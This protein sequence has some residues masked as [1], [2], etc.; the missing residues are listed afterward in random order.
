M[1]DPAGR[2]MRFHLSNSE[3]PT[4]ALY[5]A[6]PPAVHSPRQNGGMRFRRWRAPAH[7]APPLPLLARVEESR[8]FVESGRAAIPATTARP[9]LWYPYDTL[10]GLVEAGE[11]LG[12]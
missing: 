5:D 8:R 2:C 3:I 1:R 10:A 9:D 11:W 4:I 12:P 7:A 6:P